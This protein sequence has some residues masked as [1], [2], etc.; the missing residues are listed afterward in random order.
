MGDAGRYFIPIRNEAVNGQPPPAA[1][2]VCK[3]LDRTVYGPLFVICSFAG[4]V[5]EMLASIVAGT[6]LHVSSMRRSL[7][8]SRSFLPSAFPQRERFRPLACSLPDYPA[9]VRGLSPGAP[10]GF[11]TWSVCSLQRSVFSPSRPLA[12]CGPIVAVW[13]RVRSTSRSIPRQALD[14]KRSSVV[15]GQIS[16]RL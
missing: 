11:R 7:G 1:P 5:R 4:S 12:R 9:R 3:R 16:K 13:H 2:R 6:S 15:Y 10:V 8:C 14:K